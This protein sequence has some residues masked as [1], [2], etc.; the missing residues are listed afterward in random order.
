LG[1]QYETIS[2]TLASLD[3]RHGALGGQY[4]TISQALASLD[5]RHGALGGQYETISQTLAS[6]DQR[7][8]ALGGQYETI[9]QALANLDQRHGSLGGQYETISQALANLDQ[10][11]GSL[12]GQYETIS[13]ALANLDQRHG[14]LGGQ[15]EAICQI[16]ANLQQR[17]DSLE[18][19]TEV[20]CRS[21][22]L[23]EE[24][25]KR[26]AASRWG[27]SQLVNDNVILVEHPNGGIF[28]VPA[29]NWG[30]VQMFTF[31]HGFERGT[32]S[33]LASL[34]QQGMTAVDIGAHVG[35]HTLVLADRVG[36]QGRVYCFEPCERSCNILRNN[37]FTNG[38]KNATV[39][40]I[41]ISD[42][43]G[44]CKFFIHDREL[45]W[46]S[47]YPPA[48]SDSCTEV[49]VETARLDDVIPIDVKVDLVKIDA[50]GA[51]LGILDGM[52]R[53]IA[54]NPAIQIILEFGPTNIVRAGRRPEDL[55]RKIRAL[56]FSI[57]RI[58]ETSGQLAPAIDEEL[59]SAYSVNLLLSR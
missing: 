10:R 24:E 51:E 5:Q 1:G 28:G 43:F 14:S 42:Y 49:S 41:A 59:L 36:S 29:E 53:I 39:R 46:S 9:S 45:T 23:Q 17:Q 13:Q 22:Q 52:Q 20:I 21:V 58:D 54:Q 27:Q 25:Q 37:L 2:Q 19:R 50:E 4:E 31:G 57:R 48:N 26:V 40:Q 35:L 32:M 30:F 34:C 15:C 44:T 11:H 18:N 33:V 7:H 47:M 56:G 38:C 16:L 8:G 6:L 12:G 3:Q 55:I